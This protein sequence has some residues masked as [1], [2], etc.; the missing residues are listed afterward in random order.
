MKK[1]LVLTIL[2]I[3]AYSLMA[4]NYINSSDKHE[5][6]TVNTAPEDSSGGYGT[7]WINPRQK[8]I[9]R[10]YFSVRGSG[11]MLIT[12]QYKYYGDD[13]WTDYMMVS[14][15]KVADDSIVMPAGD[16]TTIY[17]PFITDQPFSMEFNLRDLDTTTA[18]LDIAGAFHLDSAIYNRIDTVSLPLT[19]SDST[20]ACEKIAWNF[21]W[22]VLFVD[23]NDVT[24]GKKIFYSFVKGMHTPTTRFPITDT[25][26]GILWKAIVKE[27]HYVKGEC[28]FGFD[29]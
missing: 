21:P 16:D 15:P 23:K 6:A 25:S 24:A 18:V 27:N 19:L 29:W 1:L 3:T 22:L 12:L 5:Y 8:G 10:F 28:T 14:V 26:D 9:E 11:W 13:G 7:N 17:I 4:T 2:L 20:F